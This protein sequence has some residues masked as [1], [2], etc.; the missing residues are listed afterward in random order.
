[1]SRPTAAFGIRPE[2]VNAFLALADVL[3]RMGDDGRRAV[4]EQRPEQWGS[5]VR[6]HARQ[7]AAA[8]CGF[9]P[10][11]PA[12]LAFALAQREPAGVWGG[13]DFTPAA[14]RKESAA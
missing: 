11:Q 10:A 1:M 2:A 13:Q 3:N 14:R 9:C 4:C 6:A 12:C 8:A 7:D 5:D